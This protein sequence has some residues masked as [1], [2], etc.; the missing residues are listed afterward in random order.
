MCEAVLFICLFIFTGK[1]EYGLCGVMREAAPSLAKRCMKEEP[2]RK[3]IARQWGFP[4]T[5]I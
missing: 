1:T 3:S 2:Q 5:H 4:V